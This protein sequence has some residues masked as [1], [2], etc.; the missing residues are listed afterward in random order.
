MLQGSRYKC[1][2][3]KEL[4]P[5]HLFSKSKSNNR[6]LD[7]YCKSCRK[8]VKSRPSVKAAQKRCEERC[9]DKR[10]A[11]NR[12]YR[13]SNKPYFAAKNREYVCKKTNATPNWLTDAQRAQIQNLYWLAQDLGRVTG[14]SYHVDH[15]IPVQGKDV[16]GL[17]VPWNLQVL[18]ADLNHRK[19]NKLDQTYLKVANG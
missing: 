12:D 11:Y 1:S 3:C 6:G 14:E 4:K 17:H 9:R 5:E 7:Y 8:E 2:K 19:S 13:K 18:P 16:C 15:I 10:R